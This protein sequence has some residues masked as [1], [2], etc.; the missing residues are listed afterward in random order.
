VRS[1]VQNEG[2][3]THQRRLPVTVENGR[4]TSIRIDEIG[5]RVYPLRGERA[6]RCDPTERNP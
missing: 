6:E 5:T 4:I 2:V 3:Y 1:C